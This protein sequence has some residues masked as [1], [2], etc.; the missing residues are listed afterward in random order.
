MK[1]T[2][3]MHSAYFFVYSNSLLETKQT[4]GL[5][6]LH[7]GYAVVGQSSQQCMSTDQGS[8]TGVLKFP[9]RGCL[10]PPLLNIKTQYMNSC[11]TSHCKAPVDTRLRLAI[12]P[13]DHVLD[14]GTAPEQQLVGIVSRAVQSRSIECTDEVMRMSVPGADD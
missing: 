5:G 12:Y 6:I 11:S 14:P 2:P 9:H 7:N 4:R 1:K 13:G 8:P 3:S 10:T